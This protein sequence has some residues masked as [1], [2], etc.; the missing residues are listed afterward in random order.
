MDRVMM[1]SDFL[2]YGNHVGL[3]SEEI[4]SGG[5]GLGVSVIPL[6]CVRVFLLMIS[7]LR[8]PHKLS[9]TLL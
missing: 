8:I 2:G 3:M 7:I 5:E 4:S 9:L 6:P 1:F